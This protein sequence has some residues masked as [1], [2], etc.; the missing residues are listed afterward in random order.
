MTDISGKGQNILNWWRDN[1]SEFP[2]LS[3]M[4]RQLISA[5]VSPA[6]AER[7]F[8]SVGKMYDDLKN[9]TNEGTLESQLI[10]NRNYLDA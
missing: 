6:C 10:V 2:N 8:L 7:I 3:K 1:E 5:H 4:A 9:S